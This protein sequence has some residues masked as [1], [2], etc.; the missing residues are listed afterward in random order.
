MR[1]SVC[2]LI[3]APLFF[4]AFLLL[5]STTNEISVI[6]TT[7]NTVNGK[8][9][10]SSVHLIADTNHTY[11]SNGVL[12]TTTPHRKL[13]VRIESEFYEP[14][15]FDF[16]VSDGP[17]SVVT[18]GLRPT[19][20][21]TGQVRNGATDTPIPD[22]KIKLERQ[23]KV[24][25]CSTDQ[26]GNYNFKVPVGLYNL[27]TDSPNYDVYNWNYML[28]PGNTL[29]ELIYLL[30]KD[31]TT[32]SFSS[33]KSYSFQGKRQGHVAGYSQ[34]ISAIIKKNANGTYRIWQDYGAN[35]SKGT[36][37][38]YGNSRQAWLLEDGKT[39]P[40]S[41]EA[42]YANKLLIKANE[43]FMDLLN[44][45]RSKSGVRV[46]KQGS[47]AVNGVD[48]E[49]IRVVKDTKANW[50]GYYDCDITFWVMKGGKLAGMP[51]KMSGNISGRDEHYFYF[52]LDVECSITDVGSKFVIPEL[53]RK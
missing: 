32:V 29:S 49:K 13:K 18:V 15:E 34:G 27:K 35:G 53:E 20:G 43:D 40:M 24:Y 39:T 37:T 28:A 48:C 7:I 30:P 21:I 9:I 2:K 42:V 8:Q 4:V 31:K 3:F 10:S 47:E 6:I 36:C 12:E 23:G 38:I 19:T 1:K 26:N 14:E 41:A 22:I 17:N 44:S 52:D 33:Y 45:L 25:E 11:K 5:M 50:V 51:T 16:V 46:T